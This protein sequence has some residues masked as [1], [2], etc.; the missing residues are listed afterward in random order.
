MFRETEI[1]VAMVMIIAGVLSLLGL[2]QL[3]E[4]IVWLFQLVWQ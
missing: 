3:G 4:I 1:F 2:W